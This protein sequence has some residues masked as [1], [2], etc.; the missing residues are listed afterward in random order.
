VG[1]AEREEKHIIAYAE[2]RQNLSTAGATANAQ[3]FLVNTTRLDPLAYMLFGAHRV[4]V[5]TR[6]LECDEWL[7]I[8]G[9]LDVL[10]DVER[11]KVMIESCMLRVF[12]GITKLQSKKRLP[13][14]TEGKEQESEDEDEEESVRDKSLSKEE[15]KQLDFLAQDVVSLL[16][17]FNAHRASVQS[18]QS[19]RPGTPTDSAFWASGVPPPQD[20][21]SGYSTPRFMST[22]AGLG[23]VGF[24]SRPSTPSRLR[25]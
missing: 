4:K 19:T 16:N 3:K 6:G 20:R 17:N 1:T 2:K 11:L 12:E 25:R 15:I 22:Q 8:I 10:D 5:T 21:R 9:S 23:F 14:P 24:S 13:P 7:P 18:R